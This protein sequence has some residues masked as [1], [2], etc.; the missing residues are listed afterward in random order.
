MD[1]KKLGSSS[2]HT[3]SQIGRR[4][5]L[6]QWWV[7]GGHDRDYLLMHTSSSLKVIP[8]QSPKDGLWQCDQTC[9]PVLLP[10]V[11]TLNLFS[12]TFTITSPFFLKNVFFFLCMCVCACVYACIPC[13]YLCPQRTEDSLELE[14]QKAV[15]DLDECRRPYMLRSS[16]RAASALNCRAGSLLNPLTGIFMM[17]SWA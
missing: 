12:L 16:A 11:A 10:S 8:C 9:W 2:M 3:K 6:R 7:N 1:C 14:L 4:K 17:S 13:V 5:R 15:N